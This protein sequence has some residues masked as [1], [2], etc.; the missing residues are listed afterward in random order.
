M[1]SNCKTHQ[2]RR[3]VMILDYL[4]SQEYRRENEPL[5]KDDN[6]IWGEAL[7]L[8][9][10]LTLD[11][12]LWPICVQSEGVPWIKALSTVDVFKVAT[13]MKKADTLLTDLWEGKSPSD[14]HQLIHSSEC[15]LQGIFMPIVDR[16]DDFIAYRTI[17]DY[18]VC[19]QFFSF[20]SR[21]TLRNIPNDTVMEE[22][23]AGDKSL[24]A[25]DP[26]I[27]AAINKILM[28]WLRNFKV[29][30]RPGNGPGSTADAGGRSLEDKY[31][32]M[33]G[34]IDQM[35]AYPFPLFGEDIHTYLYSNPTKPLLRRSKLVCVP[36]TALTRRTICE[37]PAILQF[38]QQMVKRDLYEYMD[39]NEHIHTHV[40][41][42]DQSINREAARIGSIT[43]SISTIDLHAASDSVSWDL[44]RIA[45]RN[46]PL[47]RWLYAT[48]SKEVDVNG[49]VLPLKKFAPMGSA[50]CFPIETLIFLACCNLAMG[51][52]GS[53]CSTPYYSVY[54]DDIAISTEAVPLVCDILERLGFTINTD[55][56]FSH[57]CKFPYRESCGVEYVFGKNVKPLRIPRWFSGLTLDP[58]HSD[59]IPNLVSLANAA[60]DNGFLNLRQAI[61]MAFDVLPRKLRPFFSNA[62]D[63]AL[64]TWDI[65]CNWKGEKRWN[66]NYQ[67]SEI[68][69]YVPSC[70]QP[71]GD[72]GVRYFDYWI[73]KKQQPE[74]R[75]FDS[76]I[77]VGHPSLRRG[78]AAWVARHDLS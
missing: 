72:E 34:S 47:L 2:L 67:R 44:A 39:K 18:R 25:P 46:T 50:L 66:R 7:Y 37:E 52:V 29:T 14:L 22:F 51:R 58:Y 10:M 74:Y 77:A 60:L 3:R 65:P 40:R 59:R 69:T 5:L 61:L 71:L 19:H 57:T 4:R 9:F 24:R 68:R 31:K 16:V 35:L 6:L 13:A 30:F 41:L 70:R 48:R 11:L 49:Y 8:F 62:S 56:T 21:V 73:R 54:G 12:G 78:N 32:I 26:A 42:D 28:R 1:M 38:F 53:A 17:R 63:S 75:V 43:G 45:F 55:K 76:R 27:S 20:L 23:I 64:H 15:D 33:S 36:K